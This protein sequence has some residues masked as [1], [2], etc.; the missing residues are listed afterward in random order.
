MKTKYFAVSILTAAV[1]AVP[2]TVR[3]DDHD[4]AE[5]AKQKV[6]NKVAEA[7]REAHQAMCKGKHGKVTDKTDS[8]VT[9]DGK[10]HAMTLDARVTKQDEVIKL[11]NIAVGDTV[12]Y[13]TQEAADGTQQVAKIMEID[14][15]DK[16]R[17][18]EKETD[19]DTD[20]KVETPGKDKKIEVE[21]K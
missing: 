13:T 1:L 14:P 21:V 18:R 4:D 20:V 12:C 19:T 2:G 7:N 6:E 15:N 11:K 16:V 3:A 8:T 5:K 17:V 10:R 9:I